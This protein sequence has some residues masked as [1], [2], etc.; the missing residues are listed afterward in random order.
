LVQGR[1]THG[2]F[3]ARCLS[4]VPVATS[5]RP[6]VQASARPAGPRCRMGCAWELLA[7]LENPYRTNM[8]SKI[9]LCLPVANFASFQ[10][11]SAHLS[12]TLLLP[13]YTFA[14]A[15]C[16]LRASTR[17][18]SLTSPRTSACGLDSLAHCMMRA[19]TAVLISAI[20]DSE[21][22]SSVASRLVYLTQHWCQLGLSA[23]RHQSSSTSRQ[24]SSSSSSFD[25]WADEVAPSACGG[26]LARG[27][28]FFVDGRFAAVD[29]RLAESACC[30][31]LATAV[32]TLE[33]PASGRPAS[34]R[35]S[36]LAWG[37]DAAGASMGWWL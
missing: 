20:S 28:D 10:A 6:C 36:G 34:G 31:R 33:W 22:L 27:C 8:C 13:K 18:L 19:S 12:R 24:M 23:R 35:V 2:S 16:P 14:L 37:G 21:V 32:V 1:G 5:M 7:C 25:C 4:S 30:G 26:P 11:S 29:E 3:S 17:I 15:T 9:R